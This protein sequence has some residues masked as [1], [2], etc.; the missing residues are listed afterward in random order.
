MKSLLECVGKQKMTT[1][2]SRYEQLSAHIKTQGS[3]NILAAGLCWGAWAAFRM[4]A[5][6]NNIK[7]IASIHPSFIVEK[8]YGG[9][10][11]SLVNACKCPTFF[12]SCSNDE[13]GTKKGGE[14]VKIL[15]DKFG[16]DKVGS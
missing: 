12:Y 7:A 9:S 8:Y 3:D 13:I 14:Y 6:Y 15:S 4:S 5:D 11:L 16:A 2:K 1:I 10:E